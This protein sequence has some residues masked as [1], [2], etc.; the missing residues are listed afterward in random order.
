[1]PLSFD[2]EELNEIYAL[3]APIPPVCREAFLTA[4]AE[5]LSKYPVVGP[6]LLH[7]VGAPLQKR[8]M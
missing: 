4:L 1:V 3:A 6:G 8:F 7:R 2:D 5:A